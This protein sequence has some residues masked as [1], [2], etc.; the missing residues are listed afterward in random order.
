MKWTLAIPVLS[1]LTLVA[2][3]PDQAEA[4]SR[5]SFDISVGFG[6][7][8]HGYRRG[9][10]SDVGFRYS[11]GRSYGRDYAPAYCPPR[12]YSAPR[13]YAPRPVYRE[14]YYRPAP[15]IYYDDCGYS[16]PTYYY[17]PAPRYYHRDYDC[18]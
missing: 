10:H 17:S 8:D 6:Y 5:S 3:L 9:H 7:S 12:Y 16:A 2:A 18:R 4:R 1:A 11:S 13:Y 15:R 14:T